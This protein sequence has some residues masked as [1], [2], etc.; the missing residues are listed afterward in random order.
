MNTLNGTNTKAIFKTE[1]IKYL[2]LNP[3]DLTY[4]SLSENL[5]QMN[6]IEKDGTYAFLIKIKKQ[7][8]F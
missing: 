1:K 6:F 4:D 3:N 7:V 5:R 2:Y 8:F